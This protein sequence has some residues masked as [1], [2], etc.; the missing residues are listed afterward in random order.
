[1]ATN[2][3]MPK[4]GYD[5]TEG[6]ILRWIKNEGETVT[7]GEPVAEIQT[8][9]VNI[10]IEAFEQESLAL[11]RLE[12]RVTR[13]NSTGEQVAELRFAQELPVA[14]V[15]GQYELVGD[16]SPTE[17]SEIILRQF[18]RSQFNAA[19]IHYDASSS[20]AAWRLR[21]MVSYKA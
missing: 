6:K 5:M 18:Q 11:Q 17:E 21:A 1:M 10:E 9:K 15:V 14:G 8:E 16:A 4:M 2:V 19:L 12:A 13:R 3:L 20:S 7:K